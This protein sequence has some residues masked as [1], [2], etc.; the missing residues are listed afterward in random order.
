MG[1]RLLDVVI[2]GAQER[3]HE[4]VIVWPS[5]EAVSFYARAGFRE[6]AEV[7]CGADDYPPM[8]LILT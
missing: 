8:E 2:A 4:F 1:A 5:Q 7:H 3:G 6:V